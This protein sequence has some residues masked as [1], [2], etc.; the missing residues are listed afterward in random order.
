MADLILHHYDEA[1]FA[2]KVRLVFGIKNLS[3]R[4]VIQPAA[5][6]TR[7]HAPDRRVPAHSRAA[8]RRRHLLRTPRSPRLRGRWTRRIRFSYPPALP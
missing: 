5:I 2:E 1:P 8:D 6:E 4:S 3:W 7:P